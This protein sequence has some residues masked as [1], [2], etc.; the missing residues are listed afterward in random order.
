MFQALSEALVQPLDT[1]EPEPLLLVM[2]DSKREGGGPGE[3]KSPTALRRVFEG[4][5][6]QET[7]HGFQDED[8]DDGSTGS[9]L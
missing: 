2:E 5:S 1:T 8:V 4:D 3:V 7:F 6:D 9:N